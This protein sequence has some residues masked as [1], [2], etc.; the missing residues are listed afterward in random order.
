MEINKIRE[1]VESE[2]AKINRKLRRK[3]LTS[4]IIILIIMS[5]A[6]WYMCRDLYRAGE[7]DFIIEFFK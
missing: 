4:D 7:F 2:I 1:K 5:F 3:K 6:I